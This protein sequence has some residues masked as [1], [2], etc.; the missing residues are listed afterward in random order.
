VSSPVSGAVAWAVSLQGVGI[1]P[2][3]QEVFE[4]TIHRL[5]P[6]R[7]VDD[8]ACSDNSIDEIFDHS[9]GAVSSNSSAGDATSQ[10]FDDEL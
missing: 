9:V 10:C 3:G 6:C 8:D 4:K 1:S 2:A 5:L 7:G